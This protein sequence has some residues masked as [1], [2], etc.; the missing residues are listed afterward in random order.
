M[1]YATIGLEKRKLQE[2]L[3]LARKVQFTKTTLV[4][5]K[6]RRFIETIFSNEVTSFAISWVLPYMECLQELCETSSKASKL[7]GTRLIPLP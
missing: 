1:R 6:R 3:G 7:A 2:P 4:Y 5:D